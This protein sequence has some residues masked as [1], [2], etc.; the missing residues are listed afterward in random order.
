MAPRPRRCNSGARTITVE[1][2][3][4]VAPDVAIADG[5]YEIAATGGAAARQMWTTFVVTRAADGWRISAIRNMR[6]SA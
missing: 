4:L 5:R 2:V 1:T 6:P 3:R